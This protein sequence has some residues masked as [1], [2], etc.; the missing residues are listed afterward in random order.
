[1][2]FE[3]D[4]EVSFIV[5][6]PFLAIGGVLIYFPVGRLT[7]HGHYNVEAFD[8]YQALKLLVIY[9]DLKAI[10]VLDTAATIRLIEIK[11]L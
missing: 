3:P 5:E 8:V 1:M 11:I 9:K 6:Y 7:M 4:P 10:I 2:D